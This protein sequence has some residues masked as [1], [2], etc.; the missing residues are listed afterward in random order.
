MLFG[1][2]AANRLGGR[3]DDQRA[4]RERFALGDQGAGADD[5][6]FAYDRLVENDGAHADKAQILDGAG[7]DDGP[8]ADCDVVADDARRFTGGNMDRTVVLDISA[9]ADPD[10]VNIAANHCVKPD[11]TI[12]AYCRITDDT[13]PCC[14]QG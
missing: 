6:S 3:A 11:A 2:H 12:G 10:V 7:M 13:S 4:G 1:R 9:V 5:R 14:D 8:M